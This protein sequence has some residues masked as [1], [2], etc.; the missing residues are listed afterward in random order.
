LIKKLELEMDLSA[1][2]MEYEKAAEIR[3][4]IIELKR[5]I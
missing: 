2:N 3:D 4:Q 1:S 5:K